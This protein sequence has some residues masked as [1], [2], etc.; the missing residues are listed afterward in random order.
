MWVIILGILYLYFVFQ[1][2][3]WGIIVVILATAVILPGFHR[4]TPTCAD[5]LKE[6][7]LLEIYKQGD[8]YG[9][10]SDPLALLEQK[11]EREKLE[12]EGRK[13]I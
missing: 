6:D 5:T 9:H 11:M 8:I 10:Y 4:R 1:G 3:L 2:N 12:K 7:H 13:R